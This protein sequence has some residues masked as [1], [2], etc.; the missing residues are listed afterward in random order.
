M[1]LFHHPVCIQYTN[2]KCVQKNACGIIRFVS[3]LSC[4][5]LSIELGLNIFLQHSFLRWQIC[6]WWKISMIIWTCP[7]CIASKFSLELTC[8]C[9]YNINTN[10]ILFVLQEENIQTCR[11][12]RVRI[13]NANHIT[14]VSKDYDYIKCW[15]KIRHMWSSY[16]FDLTNHP[17]KYFFV[18][19]GLDETKN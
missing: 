1:H 11:N 19:N 7:R 17:F 16:S 5:S 4:F 2:A 9:S 15:I 13:N 6:D 10:K 8:I 14:K 3:M 18:L 12:L